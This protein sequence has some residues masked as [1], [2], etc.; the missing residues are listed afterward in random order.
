V[1]LCGDK[2]AFAETLRRDGYPAVPSGTDL[3]SIPAGPKGW[4]VKERRGAGSR[5]IGLALDRLAAKRHAAT[6]TQPLF[7]PFVVGRE[8]SIDV[9]VDGEGRGKGAIARTRDLVHGGESQVTTT[10]RHSR[11]E[12]LC[13]EVA[14]RYGVLFHSC[15]QAIEDPAGDLHLLECNARIGGAS[16]LAMAAGLDSLRWFLLEALGGD[17]STEPFLRAPGEL[18]LVRQARDSITSVST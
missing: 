2:L 11:L 8:Y 5:R 18:R 17:T 13:L 10:R 14:T 12:E 4:V 9:Y 3:E 1:E 16:T 6:L 7:Q 15:F